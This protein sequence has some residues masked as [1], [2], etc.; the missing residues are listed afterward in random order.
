MIMAEKIALL[1]KQ[2]GWSQ[3]EL[4]EKLGVSRQSVSKWESGG[5]IPDLDKVVKLSALFGVSTDYLLLD[6]QQEISFTES[7]GPAEQGRRLRKV[8][9]D[10][11]N[12]YMEVARQTGKGIALGAALCIFSPVC[13]FLLTALNYDGRIG[14]EVAAGIGTAVLLVFVAA[15]AALC[16]V[17]GLRTEKY[18]YIEYEHLSLEYG[19]FGIVEKKRDEFAPRFRLGITLGVAGI[20]LGI[21]PLLIAGAIEAPESTEILWTAF[22]LVCVAVATFFIISVSVVNGSCQKLLE[23]GDYTPEKKDIRRR[24]GALGG[25]YWCTATAVY[26][27][28]SFITRRWDLSWIVWPVAGVLYPAVLAIVRAI[29]RGDLS[30]D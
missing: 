4:A 19:V 24:T 5:A 13:L 22:L 30:G 17:N 2:N 8:S 12:T 15:G 18:N 9:V 1:R 6:G 10:E 29:V 26:L 27:A 7:D 20:I 28:V 16:I 3:E 11:A 25:I 23:E 21:I 14:E